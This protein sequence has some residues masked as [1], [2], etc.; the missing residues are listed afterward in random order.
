MKSGIQTK[1]LAPVNEKN[2]PLVPRG[3]ITFVG[4]QGGYVHGLIGY[5]FVG[6]TVITLRIF[7]CA[8]CS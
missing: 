2:E 5:V 4:F 3:L 1:S 7:F 8:S 6:T